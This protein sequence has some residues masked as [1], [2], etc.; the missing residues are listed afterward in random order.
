[1]GRVFNVFGE[2]I[3]RGDAVADGGWRSIHQVPV[4]LNQR[5]TTADIYP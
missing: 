5:A 2:T 3:D 4:P 1:M